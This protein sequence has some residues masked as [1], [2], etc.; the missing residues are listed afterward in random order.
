MNPIIP[1]TNATPGAGAPSELFLGELAS[2]RSTGKLYLG[3]DSGIVE[4]G[5]G[6][7]GSTVSQF[8]GDG[9]A[10]EFYPIG[11]YSN[12]TVGNYLV[13]V[14]GIDQRPT[15]DWTISSA[16]SGTIT[17]ASAPPDGAT[18]VVRAFTGASGG[19]GGSGDAT[20]LQG[21]ALSDAAPSAGD[22][23]GW[24]ATANDW[25]PTQIISKV[26]G[27]VFS[28]QVTF[29]EPSTT[30]TDEL[31]FFNMHA[32][33]YQIEPKTIPGDLT[34]NYGATAQ[35]YVSGLQGRAVSDAAPTDQQALVWDNFNGVW[36]PG[37]PRALLGAD[38][39]A[40]GLTDVA[41]GSVSTAGTSGSN[42]N[43]AIAIGY[44]SHANANNA[45]AIGYNASSADN[46]VAI[47]ADAVSSGSASIAIGSN[48][49]SSGDSG[50]S[51]GSNSQNTG[52]G[53]TIGY[54]TA[55]YY[56]DSIAIGRQ[57]VCAG[58]NSIAIGTNLTAYQD[59][60]LIGAYNLGAMKDKINELVTWA[61]NNGASISPL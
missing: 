34:P 22:C 23:V 25:E 2:N 10:T 54:Q 6:T 35:Y 12:T 27:Q 4:V 46:A 15:T 51:I 45:I 37:A 41:L 38:A 11:G 9:T 48:A 7:A 61:N 60:V 59:Q 17:F 21:R 52:G 26:L 8:T 39:V 36:A 32:G 49:Q 50:I 44:V 42:S 20:S 14:G 31:A 1:K 43:H 28:Q 16:N 18:I 29:A 56:S 55:V 40:Y 53:I 30:W 58:S 13:S 57:T 19:G 24:N 47:G 5:G 33:T 3:C